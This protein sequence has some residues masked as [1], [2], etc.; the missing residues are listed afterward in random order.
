MIT[1]SQTPFVLVHG[2]WDDEHAW[3]A[4]V[5]LLSPV[6]PVVAYSRRGH[7]PGAAVD[8]RATRRD[9]EDDLARL[10]E[11]LDAGAVHVAGNSY[12]G[13]IALGLAARRPDLVQTVAVHEPPAIA[14]AAAGGAAHVVRGVDAVCEE[15]AAGRTGVAARR[16]VEEIALGPGAWGMLPAADRLTMERNAPTFL[17]EWRDRAGYD[18]DAT[19]VRACG[20][21]VLVTRGD[22]SPPWLQHVT[23]RLAALL[24][25]AEAITIPGTGHVPHQ[26]DPERYAPL[27]ARHA[28]SRTRAL[29]GQRG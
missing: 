18:I 8:P 5:P 26:T 15:I 17:A 25:E 14:L 21:P 12:G 27:L 19:A 4:L 10:I 22:G 6:A 20:V 29:H 1:T 2:S 23:D 13:L 28:A 16:F 11:D 9:H 24:P 7:A 3:D